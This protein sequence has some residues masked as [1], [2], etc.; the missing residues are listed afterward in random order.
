MALACT[1][2]SNRVLTTLERKSEEKAASGMMIPPLSRYRH[3]QGLNLQLSPYDERVFRS[4]RTL[5]AS[6]KLFREKTG[7]VPLEPFLSATHVTA[8]AR[9]RSQI[10]HL[11]RGCRLVR[12][13]F[14]F[15]ARKL[16]GEKFD[17]RLLG[18][19]FQTK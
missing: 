9:F 7:E 11:A 15:T 17:Q 6:D 1:T 14:T 19:F 5:T 3:R 8:G 4:N 10:S 12:S 18:S 16:I 2:R 13:S